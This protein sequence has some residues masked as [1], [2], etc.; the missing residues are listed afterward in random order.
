MKLLIWN[1]N[2]L[3]R[4]KVETGA[5][6]AASVILKAQRMHN[7]KRESESLDAIMLMTILI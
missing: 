6:R 5:R 7:V 4:H 1:D 2:T 3:G